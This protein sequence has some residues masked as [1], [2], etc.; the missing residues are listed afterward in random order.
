ML[1]TVF[2]VKVSLGSCVGTTAV[3]V[4]RP[5][6]LGA[7][8]HFGATVLHQTTGV[9]SSSVLQT[10][11]SEQQG[12]PISK[13]KLLLLSPQTQLIESFLRVSREGLISDRT[14]VLKSNLSCV[15][16][17]ATTS[18]HCRCHEV[19]ALTSAAFRLARGSHVVRKGVDAVVVTTKTK[20]T[21]HCNNG[22]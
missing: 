14:L 22:R 18:N 20:C 16:R 21:I 10:H 3:V 8:S 4:L 2:Y 12:L 6:S 17:A 1:H 15:Q 13:V 9:L 7:S 19:R 5:L 11:F